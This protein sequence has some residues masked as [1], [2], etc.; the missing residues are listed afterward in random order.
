MKSFTFNIVSVVPRELFYQRSLIPSAELK[1]CSSGCS[2][3]DLYGD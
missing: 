2:H 1:F 3:F